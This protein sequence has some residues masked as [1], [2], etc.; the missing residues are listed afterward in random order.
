MY[1]LLTSAV[2]ALPCTDFWSLGSIR[3]RYILRSTSSG[4][5]FWSINHISMYEN[6]GLNVVKN[7]KFSVKVLFTDQIFYLAKMYTGV[8]NLLDND[9]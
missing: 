8:L 7:L 9:L 5:W 4:L 3:E 1:L 2:N 6:S